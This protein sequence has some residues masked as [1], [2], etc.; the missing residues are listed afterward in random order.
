MKKVIGIFM[1]IVFVFV[2]GSMA[3]GEIADEVIEFCKDNALKTYLREDNDTYGYN[4]IGDCGYVISN[5]G[6]EFDDI[7]DF[8]AN[9]KDGY[10]RKY[11]PEFAN[12]VEVEFTYVGRTEHYEMICVWLKLNNG[13]VMSDYVETEPEVSELSGMIVFKR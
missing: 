8:M 4:I 11:W 1:A 5:M 13:K 2:F 6:E 12:D 7:Y 9:Y 10:L 3:F